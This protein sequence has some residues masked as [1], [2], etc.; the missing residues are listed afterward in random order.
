MISIGNYM[1]I[2]EY[3]FFS[4]TKGT[5]SRA[6][7]ILGYKTG[8]SRFKMIESISSI[9]SGMKLGSNNKIKVGK[10]NE[11]MGYTK[12]YLK[13]GAMMKSRKRSANT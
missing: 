8:L 7:Y 4:N 12:C 2:T 5:F 1:K 9:F 11:Y 13:I 3:T 10:K 6:D